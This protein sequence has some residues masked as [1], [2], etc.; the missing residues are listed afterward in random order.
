MLD[1]IDPISGRFAVGQPVPRSEDPVLLRGAG[2]YSDDETLPG[3]AHAVV[4]RSQHAHGILRGV[5]TAAARAMPGVLAVV[6]AEDLAAS[7]V[8]A[9][10]VAPNTMADGSAAP[11]PPQSPLATGKVRYVGDPV[12]L[13]IAETLNQARDAAEAVL[14]DVAP[15]PPVTTAGAALVPG[16]PLIH[17]EAPGNVALTFQAGDADAVAAAFARAS[18]VTRLA[19]R[20]NRI[21]VAPMEPRSALASFDAETERYTLRVGCQ[22]VFGLRSGLAELLGVETARVRVLTGRVGGSFGM[23][24]GPYPEYPALLHAARALGR[25]VKWT[26]ERSGSFVSDSHGRDAEVEAELALDGD[27]RFLAVRLTLAGNVGAYLSF[28]ATYPATGNALKNV[29]GTYATP[30]VEVRSRYAFTNTTPVGPYRGAG[31]PEGNL[32]MERLVDQAAAELGLDPAELRRR[33]HIRPDAMPYK[34][35][36]GML[37]DSGD[38]PALLDE[39]LRLADWEGF[40]ARRAESARQ[41]LLRG[42]GIGQYLEVT[43]PPAREMGGLRFGDDGTLTFVT[44]TLDYG[45]GHATPFAQVI[46]DRLGVPFEAIRLVQGDSDRLVAGG[47]TGGSKSLMASGAAA[48]EACTLVV[49]KGREAAA[50]ALEAAAADIEFERGRFVV[51]GTDRGVGIME[52]AAWTRADPG[53]PGYPEG[54]DVTHIHENSP[55]AFPNGCH[56]AELEIDPETGHVAVVRY[57]AVNDFGV[58]VN[59]MLVRGQVQGGVVQ[60]IGQA[61]MEQVAYDAD[62]QLLSGSFMDYALPR[63][64]DAPGFALASHPVPARTNALGVKG[65]GEAGCAGS[66]PAVMNALMDALRPA[67]VTHFDMPA[68]PERVW[69]ALQG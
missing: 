54:L 9:M 50:H 62:G 22:G 15:L 44:G 19:L 40:P 5:D 57:A 27:G 6:L 32:Y 38:F 58:E 21:V 1:A 3:Q 23:K 35:P 53:A 65:C 51:A 37:Y 56:V 66:L 8:G 24:A 13:V 64:E 46:A 12:A 14:L 63:A 18:H 16:A 47:G 30:Q 55:S 67:G 4:V 61:L 39:A 45:Q 25:P 17:D 48:V 49:E 11:R 36:S 28:A 33:N 41:G 59:P 42:R 34:A 68:T 20:N 2:R 7:G 60:G 31:R 43:A 10:P 29:I 26:D 69:R 52:L